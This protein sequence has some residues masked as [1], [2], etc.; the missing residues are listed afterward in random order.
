MVGWSSRRWR[1]RSTA[2]HWLGGSSRRASERWRVERASAFFGSIPAEADEEEGDAGDGEDNSHRR[3]A[4][5]CERCND[6]PQEEL[7]GVN[8][9]PVNGDA[10]ARCWLS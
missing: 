3:R 4:Q 6:D 1:M 10:D 9:P 5:V 7:G 2:A 8:G